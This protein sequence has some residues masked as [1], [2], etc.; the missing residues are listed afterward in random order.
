MNGNETRQVEGGMNREVAAELRVNLIR[1]ISIS[2]FYLIHLWNYLAPKLGAAVSGFIGL[3]D[4]TVS[5]PR[6]IAVTTLCLA[7]L[8]VAFIVHFLIDQRKV[9]DRLTLWSTLADIAL[10][11]AILS[12]SSGP[13]GPMVAGF[14][15]ILMLTGLRF[16]L[17]LVRI[18]TVAAAI[19][20]LTVLAVSRWPQGILENNELTTV[21]RYHQV[22]IL[23]AIIISGV[24]MG[25]IVRHAYAV[26]AD[27]LS[28]GSKKSS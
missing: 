17:R 22:M 6:H 21:P 28:L 1:I 3:G 4:V 23:V 7:W 25:Q 27:S 11:T 12:V 14:F 10:L 20:Y 8:M 9:S 18:A 2:A 26:C 16:N 24:I 15:L 19:G 13:A 5:F